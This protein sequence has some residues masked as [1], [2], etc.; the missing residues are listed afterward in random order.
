MDES[1][2][3][4]RLVPITEPI[5]GFFLED[6]PLENNGYKPRYE[7]RD[8]MPLVPPLPVGVDVP[9]R[10][11]IPADCV[12]LST[13]LAVTTMCVDAESGMWRITEIVCIIYFVCI[14]YLE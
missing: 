11:G 5:R 12:D 7:V 14:I 4:F 2:N 9:V 10:D 6:L 3:A 1:C 8:F 13:L